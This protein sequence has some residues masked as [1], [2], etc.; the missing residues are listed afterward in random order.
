M[1]DERSA[2][3]GRLFEVVRDAQRRND[4]FDQAVADYLGV[5]RT[6]ARCLDILDQGGPMTAG[7]LAERS[8]LTT[9][10]ITK[11]V[12]R[13]AEQGYVVRSP[14]PDDRRRVIVDL[15]PRVRRLAA[16]L[17]ELPPPVMRDFQALFSE[18]DLRVLI[19]YFERGIELAALR[20]ARLEAARRTRR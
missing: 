8:H 9:G 18:R 12:D 14:D 20:V 16:E 4:E 13:L 10:A 17:Y 5:S 11:I 2:L 1:G 15:V 7:Q 6:E 3:I 19:T